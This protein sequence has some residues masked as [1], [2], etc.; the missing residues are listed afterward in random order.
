MFSKN[1]LSATAVGILDYNRSGLSQSLL[2]LL[3][4]GRHQSGAYQ[5]VS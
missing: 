4:W 2:V 1:L 3:L 5:N